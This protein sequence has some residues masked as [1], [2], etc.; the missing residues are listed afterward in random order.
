MPDLTPEEQFQ[1]NLEAGRVNLADRLGRMTKEGAEAY[2]QN[3]LLHLA[4]SE[5]MALIDK[6]LTEEREFSM[7]VLSGENDGDVD[8]II[9]EKVLW[10]HRS[11]CKVID[12]IKDTLF[13]WPNLLKRAAD[14]QGGQRPPADFHP[15]I[16]ATYTK[17]ENVSDAPA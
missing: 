16:P 10:H 6:I 11:T 4:A 8:E 5:G 3:Q 14:L 17:A 2:C 1:T 15:G 12:R 9:D 13:K 7:S